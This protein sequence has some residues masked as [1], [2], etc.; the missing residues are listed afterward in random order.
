MTLYVQ[1]LEK[2]SSTNVIWTM[3]LARIPPSSL[4]ALDS[5]AAVNI[6]A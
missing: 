4:K 1:Q 6:E 5:A 3:L 2:P